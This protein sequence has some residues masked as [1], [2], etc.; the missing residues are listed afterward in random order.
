M[1]SDQDLIQ[2]YLD[3][4][5]SEPEVRQLREL[6]RADDSFLDAFL[7]AADLHGF[8]AGLRTERAP[9]KEAPKRPLL[10]PAVSTRNPYLPAIA[11]A[12]AFLVI[13]LLVTDSKSSP[14][15]PVVKAPV[16]RA[17]STREQVVVAT[18]PERRLEEL[19]I[20]ETRLRTAP[21]APEE[22]HEDRERKLVANEEE[23]R[24]IEAE[25]SRGVHPRPT[26]APLES[27]PETPT[28]TTVVASATPPTIVER[29]AGNVYLARNARDKRRARKDDAVPVMWDVETPGASSAALIRFS[30]DTWVEVL[31]NSVFRETAAPTATSGRKV[32]LA[33]GALESHIAKQ[34]PE[35]PMVFM[36]PAGEATILGTTIRLTVSHDPKGGTTL[37]VKEG[38][39]RLKNL[40][41]GKSVELVTGQFT[42]AATGAVMLPQKSFPD[43]V[44]VKFG[45]ADVQLK[46]GWVLD[47]GEEFDSARGYGWIGPRQGLQIP[48]LFWRDGSGKLLPKHR[49]R[50]PVRRVNGADPLKTTDVS[51]G[52]AGHTE[53]WYM[54]I[55]NGRY[56]VSVCV[57]DVTFEQ[58][59]HHVAVEGLQIINER[60]NRVGESIEVKDVTIEVKDGQLTMVAGGNTSSRVASDGST[61]TCINFLLIKRVR[62]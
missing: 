36:T 46:P 28:T 14:P 41:D 10:Q 6:L 61:E 21:R 51:A 62:K 11:A 53:T 30:D 55:P 16:P 22:K 15:K 31:A 59:P 27:K 54:P 34:S 58:G 29:V 60:K 35:R 19:K 18:P 49:G 17:T 40:L 50:L 32:F 39:V 1:K 52:W 37:E 3:D 57:G 42:V 47:S 8:L 33:S 48:G 9:A 25:L 12:A 7:R 4:A 20:E 44:L 23:R 2:G 24:A 26:P 45:P 5:L 43:E 56:L 38:K 13:L